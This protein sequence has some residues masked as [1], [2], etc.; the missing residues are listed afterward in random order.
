M[1]ALAAQG[2]RLV[3]NLSAKRSLEIVSVHVA[4]QVCIIPNGT[5]RQPSVHKVIC[6]LV[7]NAEK[8]LT[9]VFV[10]LAPSALAWRD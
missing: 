2:D 3:S 6:Q 4:H 7:P 8:G 5:L 9:E 10:S 1:A